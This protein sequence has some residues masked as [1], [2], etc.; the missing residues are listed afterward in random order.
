MTQVFFASLGNFPQSH[1]GMEQ[2]SIRHVSFRN[3]PETPISPSDAKQASTHRPPGRPRCEETTLAIRTTALELLAE[4]GFATLTIEEIAKRCGSSK[5]TVYRWWSGKS[6]L[7]V[8]A[9]FAKMFAV[10]P[11]PDTGSIRGDFLEQMRVMIAELNGPSGRVL[12]AL[13][14]TAQMDEALAESV[15]TRWIARRKAEGQKTLDRAIA[16][17]EVSAGT[18][19][20]LLFDLLYSPI[21][22]RLL[23]RHQPITEAFAEQIVDTVLKGFA[24][25]GEPHPS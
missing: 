18:D 21:Y 19:L 5:A 16:R 24:T 25:R 7:V 13:L 10:V 6:E 17:G 15:R 23:L 4:R 9:F 14:A 1:H 12:A 20:Q 2:A 11:F 8:D 3:M 22:F